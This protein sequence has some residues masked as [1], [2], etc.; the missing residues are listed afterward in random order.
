LQALLG[1]SFF[2]ERGGET[3]SL[4]QS[5]GDSMNCTICG[6]KGHPMTKCP[7]ATRKLVGLLPGAYYRAGRSAKEKS[8]YKYKL[9]F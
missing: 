6:E 4:T 2:G 8:R 1:S 3:A 9:V 7:L 5:I